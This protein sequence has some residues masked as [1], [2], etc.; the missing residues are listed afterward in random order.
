MDNQPIISVSASEEVDTRDG[1]GEDGCSDTPIDANVYANK[2]TA[3][4]ALLDVALL[5]MNAALLK[6]TLARGLRH[7]FYML[8]VVLTGLSI[9]LLIIVGVLLLVLGC[10]SL[11]KP[12]QRRPADI[13]N[14]VATALTTAVALINVL[15]ASFD[16]GDTGVSE[17]RVGNFSEL[18]YD[19]VTTEYP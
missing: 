9:S 4:A 7:Q 17:C 11:H 16:M 19:E 2:K 12:C 14:N 1:G 6:H 8:V 3:A 13:I 5:T 18:F 10:L 15:S